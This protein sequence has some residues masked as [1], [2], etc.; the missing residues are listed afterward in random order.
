MT[1]DHDPFD[2]RGQDRQ[3]NEQEDKA[4]LSRQTE[5]E[6]IKWLMK[7]P[8][9]RRIIWRLLERAGVFR[10]S[11]TGD[12]ASTNFNEGMRNM[13]LGLMVLINSACPEQYALMMQEQKEHDKRNADN[14]GTS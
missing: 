10:L 12:A 11:Y 3:R 4:R 7:G 6:D 1:V 13:G 8:R 5:R 14:R 2:L 9:G